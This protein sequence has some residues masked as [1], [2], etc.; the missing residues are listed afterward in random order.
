MR[1]NGPYSS[2]SSGCHDE[3]LE[4]GN[5]LVVGGIVLPI[6]LAQRR[7]IDADRIEGAIKA[8]RLNRHEPV[9]VFEEVE[10]G[11]QR[12]LS[13]GEFA[14]AIECAGFVRIA[15]IETKKELLQIPTQLRI[16]CGFQQRSVV[17]VGMAVA[18]LPEDKVVGEIA[19]IFLTSR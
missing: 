7:E 13:A 17:A 11:E 6:A 15:P 18:V 14:Q 4:R 12:V 1:I 5:R 19:S 9:H 3:R 8:C 16:G 10:I 2:Q